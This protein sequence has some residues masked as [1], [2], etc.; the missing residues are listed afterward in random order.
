MI[1]GHTTQNKNDMLQKKIEQLETKLAQEKKARLDLQTELKRVIQSNEKMKNDCEESEKRYHYLIENVPNVLWTLRSDYKPIFISHNVE[2]VLG[3]PV[4]KVLK[5]KKYFWLSRVHPDDKE[6]VQQAYQKLFQQKLPFDIEYRVQHSDKTWLWI[7]D[8][9]NVTQQVDGH[10]LA[11]G[12]FSDISTR[13][14]IEDMIKESEERYRRIVENIPDALTVHD[15]EGTILGANKHACNLFEMSIEQLLGRKLSEFSL[16]YFN[17]FKHKERLNLL[18]NQGTAVFDSH[19][20][21]SNGQ[22][23]PVNVS[24]T[25]VTKENGG[26]IQSFSRDISERKE[27]ERIIRENEAKYSALFDN[28]LNG[29]AYHKLIMDDSGEPVDYQFMHVNHAFE[30]LTGLKRE[31]IEGK[32]LKEL[33]FW[34]NE[35]IEKWVEIYSKV[36]LDGEEIRIEE[37]SPAMG[38]WFSITA[39]SPNIGYFASIFEDITFQKQIREQKEQFIRAL[40]EKNEELE[41]FTYTVSHDLKSPIITVQ[42]FLGYL[43]KEVDARRFDCMMEFM[44]YIKDAITKMKNLLDDL[45]ELSRVGRLMNEPSKIDLKELV[46]Q[47]TDTLSGILIEA[48][49]SVKIESNLPPVFGD[50]LRIK[51]LYQNLIENA[52]KYKG[53]QTSPCIQIG[54]ITED[55]EPVFYVKDN[56]MGIDPKY[57]ERIFGLFH[58]LD[59]EQSGTGI[60]LALVERIVHV[61]KGRIWV[62]SEGKDKG[63]VFKFT[64]PM[65]ENELLYG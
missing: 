8:K 1:M 47:V 20:R 22:I 12:L 26:L 50:K 32:T 56:G 38:K 28:M 30:N 63:S 35:E 7:H 34:S 43:E 23:V 64:L 16:P 4:Q 42:G 18:T 24:S 45:L 57:H 61:H 27:S 25:L 58:Q 33:D 44:G 39:Y 40:R 6:Q 5:Y 55:E 9:S 3:I 54:C 11:Y 2:S 53:K 21:K 14:R 60:G 36:A 13:I 51:E 59:S 46:N 15:F 41:R 29:F 37:Y 31:E 48:D 19:I 65:K 52:V 10:L 62:E 49:F 17:S